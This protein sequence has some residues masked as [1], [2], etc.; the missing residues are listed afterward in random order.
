MVKQAEVFR[1]LRIKVV[2]R[3]LRIQHLRHPQHAKITLH[4]RR[5]AHPVVRP[6]RDFIVRSVLD[7]R[8]L[9]P[10]RILA[11]G[12]IDA[13]RRKQD[14]I[15]V[16]KKDLLH[17]DF[18]AAALA[19]G[20]IHN[21][22]VVGKQVNDLRMVAF[23][24]DHVLP[25]VTQAVKQVCLFNALCDRKHPG[26]RLIAVS[27]KRFC[28]LHHAGQL[29]QL[30]VSV[31]HRF[32]RRRNMHERDPRLLRKRIEILHD[33]VLGF[34]HIDHDLRAACK[35]RFKVHFALSAVKM[36]KLRQVVIFGRKVLLRTLIPRG[37][38]A[39][40][41]IRAERK[42]NNLRHRAGDGNLF[43]LR[44]Q[45]HRAPHGIREFAHSRLRRFCS[46]WRCGRR[47]RHMLRFH[48]RRRFCRRFRGTTKQRCR[49]ERGQYK[50]KQSFHRIS[51]I[52][53][54]PFI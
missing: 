13:P 28:L 21:G 10:G 34:A 15:R 53:H 27:G 12:S 48:R 19:G 25:R 8:H 17:I 18:V 11:H 41:L 3:C 44:G 7:R 22:Q 54:G 37:R 43:D 52:H 6:E 38:D 16:P 23:R 24:S 30:A 29:A 1:Y 36:P 20:I 50:S 51:S 4:G 40:E 32:R 49:E 35:Q 47:G 45:F 39:H 26:I 9:L 14:H 33:A 42:E 46:L 2:L 31:A 5:E